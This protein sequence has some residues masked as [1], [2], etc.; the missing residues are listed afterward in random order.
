M[1]VALPTTADRRLLKAAAIFALAAVYVVAWVP[2]VSAQEVKVTKLEESR[3]MADGA[4]LAQLGLDAGTIETCT[5]VA[6]LW[7]A[8]RE[9]A[10]PGRI[11][12]PM[13]QRILRRIWHADPEIRDASVA[14]STTN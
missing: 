10:L 4:L 6:A 11:S 1:E 14:H 5:D 2:P 13:Q 12:E 3:E 8:V 7:R 9:L